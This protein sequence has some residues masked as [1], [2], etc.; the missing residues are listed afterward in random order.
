MWADLTDA[1]RFILHETGTG[2]R[3]LTELFN[4]WVVGDDAAYWNRKG[5][6][7]AALIEAAQLLVELG[8]AEVWAEPTGAREGALMVALRPGGQL[9]PQ[10]RSQN[11]CP[12][13]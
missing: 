12:C 5:P 6:Y 10:R 13:R 11:I 2:E 3:S 8:L 1:Q 9:G 7:V 4:G